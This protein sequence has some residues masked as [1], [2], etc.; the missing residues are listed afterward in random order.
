MKATTQDVQWKKKEIKQK[1]HIMFLLFSSKFSLGIC[2]LS[3]SLPLILS[4]FLLFFVFF[5][6]HPSSS[7]PFSS[8]SALCS[9]DVVHNHKLSIRGSL[10]RS[11]CW[12]AIHHTGVLGSPTSLEWQFSSSWSLSLSLLLLLLNPTFFYFLYLTSHLS[13]SPCFSV[14]CSTFK[15]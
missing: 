10:W 11:H 6:H 2:V 4:L 13:T 5:F 1:P 9:E 3:L 15:E 14:L 7:S 12:P 8:L